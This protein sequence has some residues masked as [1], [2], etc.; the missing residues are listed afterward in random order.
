LSSRRRSPD[1]SLQRALRAL[2]EAVTRARAEELDGDALSNRV[3][4]LSR[5]V[6]TYRKVELSVWAPWSPKRMRDMSDDELTA[7]LERDGARANRRG[8]VQ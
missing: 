6:D 7:E 1:H 3:L 5:A 2:D 8:M 4:A